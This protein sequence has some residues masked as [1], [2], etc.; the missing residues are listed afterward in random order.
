M[1]LFNKKKNKKGFF[2]R[3]EDYLG[4]FHF[5]RKEKESFLW[6]HALQFLNAS[7]FMGVIND[8]VFKFL[9]VFLFIDLQGVAH[10]SEILFWVGTIYVL[11]FLLFSPAAGVLA[12][13]FS[14]Q[15][16]II[17]LKF[18]GNGICGVFI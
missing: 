18:T 8:N 12:D 9:I 13:R 5:A 1:F 16:M 15:R 7:Q 4:R 11:P 2:Q 6:R 3:W 14:K 17:F 10:S